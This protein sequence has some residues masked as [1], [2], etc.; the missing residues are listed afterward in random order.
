MLSTLLTGDRFWVER[1]IILN[2]I[3]L[4]RKTSETYLDRIINEKYS[5]NRG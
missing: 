4:L 2:G 1:R 5:Y 3:V